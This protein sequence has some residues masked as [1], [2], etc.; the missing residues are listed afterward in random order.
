[1]TLL[2]G[3]VDWRFPLPVPKSL[4]GVLFFDFGNVYEDSYQLFWGDMRYTAGCG[5]RYATPI[6]PLR[7][8]VGYQINPPADARFDRYELH[9]SIGQAF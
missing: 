1:L 5:V 2:E 6:G 4:E 7:L 9:F 8:D 3:N